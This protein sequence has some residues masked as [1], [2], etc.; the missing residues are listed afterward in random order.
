MGLHSD[1]EIVVDRVV[2]TEFETLEAIDHERF[3]RETSRLPLFLKQQA[4]ST[5]ALGL[6]GNATG[7]NAK[8][9]RDLPV[10]GATEQAMKER[11]LELGL[12]QPVGRMEGL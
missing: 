6:A 3:N 5:D 1:R 7:R 4:V 12:L 11:G 2:L 10:G 8:L 9:A